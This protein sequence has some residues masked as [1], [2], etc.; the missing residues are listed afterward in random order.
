MFNW[1]T[2]GDH[3]PPQNKKKNEKKA[4]PTTETQIQWKDGFNFVF[5]VKLKKQKKQ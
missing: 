3:L 1:L 5:P 2:L 4:P